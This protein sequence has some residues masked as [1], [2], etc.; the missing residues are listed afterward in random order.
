MH[1]SK[2]GLSAHTVHNYYNVFLNTT[3]NGYAKISQ[4]HVH[5]FEVNNDALKLH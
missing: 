5:Y 2:V 1:R 3:E 4:V